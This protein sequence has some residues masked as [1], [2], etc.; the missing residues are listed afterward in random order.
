MELTN[1]DKSFEADRSYLLEL[2]SKTRRIFKKFETRE[3]EQD[4]E[5][6]IFEP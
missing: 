6:I 4:F 2:A 1:N 3:K 5:T